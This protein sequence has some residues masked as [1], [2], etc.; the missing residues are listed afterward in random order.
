MSK[1]RIETI[2]PFLAWLKGYSTKDLSKDFLAGLTVVIVLIPQVMAYA[3]LAGMPPVHGLYAAFLGTAAAALWG[4]SR[5]LSTGPAAVVSFL[6][7]TA[8]IPLAKPESAEFVTLAII[9]ALMVGIFQILMGVFR[10]GFLMNFVSHSVIGGFTT[11]AA[12]IIAA[13]QIPALFGFSIEQHEIVLQNFFEI[14]RSLPS[15]HLLS[16][17]IGLVSVAIIIVSKRFISKA[18]P[19][20]LIVMAGGIVLSYTLGLEADGVAVIGSIDAALSMPSVPY[21][22]SAQFLA[23]IPNALIIAV[24]GFLEGFAIS[25]SISEKSKQKIAVNQELIGQGIGNIASSLFRGY[26]IAGSFSRTAVNYAAGAVTGLSSVFAS[27]FVLLTILLFTQYLYY[28]PKTI[29]SAI[30]IAA[31]VDLIEFSKFRQTFNLSGTDGIVITTTFVIAFLSKPDTAIFIGIATSLILFLR[32]T[33]A[34]KVVPIYFDFQNERF[35]KIEMYGGPRDFPNL[36]MLQVDMS[37]YFGNVYG[38]RDQILDLVAMKGPQLEHVVIS[39]GSVNYFDVSACEVF[40]E[41]FEDLDKKGLKVYTMYRKHQVEEIFRN[42][43]LEDKTIRL[44]DIKGFKKEF[45]IQRNPGFQP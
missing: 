4:S 38:I 45:I 26:P 33:I 7:L 2:F 42:S 8:L 29:L 28:L 41:L 43:G 6:V 39:F 24:I 36:L 17:A 16:A 35:E 27:I 22:S 9:L 40:A 34:V 18:F 12:I 3:S 5:H 44:R 11:A 37:I 15:T 13:T 30:V 31:L 21:V 14:V 25:K 20:G 23:L 19:S 1:R 10:L 32:K